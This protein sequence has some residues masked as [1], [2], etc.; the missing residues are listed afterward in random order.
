[1]AIITRTKKEHSQLTFATACESDDPREQ[2]LEAKSGGLRAHSL[3]RFVVNRL[4]IG[5]VG[6][7]IRE[8]RGTA[9]PSG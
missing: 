7:T 6:V 8:L 4:R 5:I 9:F 3:G 1:M 2:E